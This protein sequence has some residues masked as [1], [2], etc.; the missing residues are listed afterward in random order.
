MLWFCGFFNYADRQALSAVFPLLKGEFGISDPELGTLSS[1][2][3]LLY[4]L[5]SPFTGYTVGNNNSK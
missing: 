2:F 5:T 3:M 1:A 4:A